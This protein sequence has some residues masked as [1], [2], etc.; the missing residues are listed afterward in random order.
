MTL[1]TSLKPNGIA[2]IANG[3]M[4]PKM[5]QTNEIENKTPVPVTRGS[6]AKSLSQ[7]IDWLAGTFKKGVE[8]SYPPILTQKYIPCKGYLNYS[9]GSQ[10]EDGRRSY[11]NPN[12]P[13]WGT[14]II[15]TGK[16]LADC[17][18]PA[19]SLVTSLFNAG[20]SFSRI[21]LAIDAKN[22][23][24]KP[25]DAT[26]YIAKKEIKTRAKKFP[27]WYDPSGNGYTQYVGRKASEIYL[28]LYDKAAEMG[29]N[30]DWARVEIVIRG[31]RAARAAE[32]IIQDVDFRSLVRGYC[33]FTSWDNWN[34]IMHAEAI[35]LPADRSSSN[36]LNWLF[37][38]AAPS[39]AREMALSEEP[40]IIFLKFKDIVMQVYNELNSEQTVN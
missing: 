34:E 21:D 29:K 30:E 33:D 25:S 12:H 1:F 38:S 18:M 22:F 11:C 40:E 6:E 26:E 39:L 13:E 10:F 24:L 16:A 28:R 23:N 17:P 31:K 36:T 35:E 4:K 5:E 14:H 37:S 32:Q 3:R 9:E 19:S 8:I 27:A 20:F 2:C 15:W 7:R